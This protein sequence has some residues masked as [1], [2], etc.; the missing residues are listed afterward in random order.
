[1]P[2]SVP[3]LCAFC[4][5]LVTLGALTLAAL[6]CSAPPRHPSDP[7]NSDRFERLEPGNDG[8]WHFLPPGGR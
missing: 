5:A 7:V 8:G 6:A 1:M 4:L 3:R 2:D